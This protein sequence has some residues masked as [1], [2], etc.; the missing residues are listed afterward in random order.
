MS[1]QDTM[2]YAGDEEERAKA[3]QKEIE[4]YQADVRALQNDI[5]EKNRLISDLREKEQQHLRDA[6]RLRMQASEEQR[7]EE[8]ERLR[9]EQEGS[10]ESLMKKAAK[11]SI[12]HGL[13]G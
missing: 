8:Q 3:F 4:R 9:H 5:D 1:S 11:E 13:L 2:N 7:H 6:Q 12:R 10:K